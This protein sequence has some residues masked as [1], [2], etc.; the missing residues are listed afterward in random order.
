MS[1]N[2]THL[3]SFWYVASSR[4]FTQAATVLG[5]S[6]PTLTRQVHA[7][8]ADYGVPLF[9]RSTRRLV[10][11]QEGYQLFEMCQ[12]IFSGLDSVEDFLKSQNARSV[13][14]H[15][16]QHGATAK[17]LAHY[18]RFFPRHRFDVEMAPSNTIMNSLL[19]RQC[20]FGILTLND[21]PPE[22]EY[23]K[24]ST[25]KLIV[26][27]PP[28]HPWRSRRKLSIRELEGKPAVVGSHQ[29]QARRVLDES[30]KRYNVSLNVV[31][32]VDS[33]EVVWDLVRQ[34]LGIGVIGNT[35]LMEELVGHHLEFEEDTA[36]LHVHFAC[37]RER[38][39]TPQFKTMFEA[40][41]SHLL[42][43]SW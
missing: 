10:L 19:A 13:S 32:V 5:I 8:E 36:A 20:D 2:V 7:L 40:A 27:V 26:L 39:R 28:D 18:Y 29:G 38:L 35:G 43:Q 21:A 23:F 34:G 6:Q 33:S 41:R 9:N 24:I 22:F 30:L 31:Q 3:R 14:I 25:G 15:S 1:I 4:S 37:R 17:I 12:P 11:T 42:Q 16:V